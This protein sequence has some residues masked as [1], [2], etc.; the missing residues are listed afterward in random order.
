MS[1][2]LTY[3]EAQDQTAKP[4]SPAGRGWLREACHRLRRAIQ[5]MNYASRRVVERQAPWIVDDQWHRK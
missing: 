2:Q 4:A 5:E 3:Q 1:V